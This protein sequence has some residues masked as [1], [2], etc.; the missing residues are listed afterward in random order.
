MSVVNRLN[1]LAGVLCLAGVALL[2]ALFGSPAL[3]S[4]VGSTTFAAFLAL[5]EGSSGVE[6]A[7]CTPPFSASGGRRPPLGAKTVTR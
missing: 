4:G 7:V 6:G 5:A 2:A 3:T 1:L